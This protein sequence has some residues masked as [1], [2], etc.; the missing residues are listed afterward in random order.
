MQRNTVFGVFQLIAI[1]V[2]VTGPGLPI[3]GLHSL[4]VKGSSKKPSFLSFC[5]LCRFRFSVAAPPP[6]T[7]RHQMCLQD[8]FQLNS[9]VLRRGGLVLIIFK[10]FV[11]KLHGFPCKHT[12]TLHLLW[13]VRMAVHFV[14][15]QT[16]TSHQQPT[17]T[18]RD[19][20]RPP[21]DPPRPAATARDPPRTPRHPARPPRPPATS[22]DPPR[23]LATSRDPP[24]PPAT[25]R[26][27]AATRPRPTATH[28]DPPDIMKVSG[29]A[30]VTSVPRPT[31][32]HRDS[33]RPVETPLWHLKSLGFSSRDRLLSYVAT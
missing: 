3:E 13:D 22:R 12:L 8:G 30:P 32:T 31:A 6:A 11:V 25:P 33:P 18:T 20:P 23:P 15:Q 14:F 26:D 29:L 1:L 17:V 4:W 27:P 24:R 9:L 28:R 5:A 2:S 7:S 19:P 21:R 16:K 10:R